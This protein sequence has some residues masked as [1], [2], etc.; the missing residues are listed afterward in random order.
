M[1][2][3]M[4]LAKGYAVNDDLEKDVDRMMALRIEKLRAAKYSYDELLV[5]AANCWLLADIRG[6]VPLKTEISLPLSDVVSKVI[7]GT[8]S[9]AVAATKSNSGKTA[10]DARHNKPG[11][12]REMS[13]ELLAMW[14][15]GM[16]ESRKLCA[17]EWHQELGMTEPTARKKLQ[18]T[19]NP[20]P[21]PAKK[22]KKGKT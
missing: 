6:N 15:S 9:K 12:S 3:R 5:V 20:D 2:F 18:G 11:G 22:V 7:P 19:P 16:Y 10:V 8:V 17:E 13:D 1:A 14:M 21:W 4:G